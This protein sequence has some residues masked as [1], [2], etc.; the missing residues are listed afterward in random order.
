MKNGLGGAI[1]QRIWERLYDLSLSGMNIGVDGAVTNSGEL[2]VIDFFA[3]HLPTDSGGIVLDVG[4]NV[5]D[6]ASQLIARLGGR[7]KIFCFEPSRKTFEQL[8]LRLATQK[9]VELFNFG[10]SDSEKTSI[11]YSNASAS[12]LASVYNRRLGH[13]GINFAQREEIRLRR[14]DD[15]CEE[16]GI[17]RINLLKLDVEGHELY[18]LRG[19]ESLI[20]ANRIDFIQFEFG[21]CN[22]DSRTYFQDFFYL[23]NPYFE[24]FRVLKK[25]LAPVENYREAY[26]IFT[27]TNY[28]AISRRQAQC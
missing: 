8:A 18:V 17:K 11:L 22:I 25:G 13:L 7:V 4:A 6:Y 5:G 27:T 24:V 23:L 1:F 2:W 19:A 14:L 10:F 9:N 3:K 21:G 15:F 26:E 28:L 20:N 16:R 12:G